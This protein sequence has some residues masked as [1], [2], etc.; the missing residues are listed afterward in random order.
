VP[1]YALSIHF[2]SENESEARLFR[3]DM[4]LF[5]YVAVGLEPDRGPSGRA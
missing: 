4:S 3:V 5:F 2:L 1:T